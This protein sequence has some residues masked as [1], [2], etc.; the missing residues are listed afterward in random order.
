MQL[1]FLLISIQFIHSITISLQNKFDH[2]RF[3]N[4]LSIA[5]IN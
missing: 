4:P 3:N 2:I 5:K 1:I